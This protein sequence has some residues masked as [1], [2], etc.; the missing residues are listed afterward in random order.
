MDNGSAVKAV[1]IASEGECELH[2][3]EDRMMSCC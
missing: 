3:L 2:E 1:E